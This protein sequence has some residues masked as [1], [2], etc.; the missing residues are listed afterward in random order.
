LDHILPLPLLDRLF[1]TAFSSHAQKSE[2]TDDNVAPAP[3]ADCYDMT[4]TRRG[5]AVIFN[6]VNFSLPDCPK[7][8][9]SDKDCDDLIEMLSDLG[10]EVLNYN[11]LRY[12]E[13]L[14]A[15]EQGTKR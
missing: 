15:L 7:R 1:L 11:D 6:H 10:F 8:N 4:H 12:E 2:K 5:I 3:D 13:L 14:G 9:G